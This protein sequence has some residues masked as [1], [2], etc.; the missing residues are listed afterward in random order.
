MTTVLSQKGQV[1]LPASVREALGLEPGDDFEITLE[2]DHSIVLRQIST[3]P[4]SGLVDHLLSA[5]SDFEVPARKQ[6]LP[7]LPL[8]ED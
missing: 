4:N 1:V 7:R 2:D 6:D 3:P 8:I 5:P